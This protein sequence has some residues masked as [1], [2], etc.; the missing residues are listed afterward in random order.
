MFKTIV[1]NNFNTQ[2]NGSILVNGDFTLE[3]LHKINNQFRNEI[4][5]NYF[6]RWWKIK[7]LEYI[8]QQENFTKVRIR[9]EETK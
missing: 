3:E 2:N 7:G 1:I 4:L 9:L 6:D 5:F 8:M